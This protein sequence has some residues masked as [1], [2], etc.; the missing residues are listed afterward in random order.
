MNRAE[1]RAAYREARKVW[2]FVQRFGDAL[3]PDGPPFSLMVALPAKA[4]TAAARWG[5]PL[6]FTHR[7]RFNRLSTDFSRP[8]LP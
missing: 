7:P 3:P 1:F 2:A 4:R 5:D 8:R 6:R